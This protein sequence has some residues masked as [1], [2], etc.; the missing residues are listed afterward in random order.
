MKQPIRFFSMGL[1]TASLIILIVIYFFDDSVEHTSEGSVDE[2]IENLKDE[3]YHILSSSEYITLTVAN[4]TL[5]DEG[6]SEEQ[7]TDNDQNQEENTED[8]GDEED[9][10]DNANDEQDQN[11]NSDD[12]NNEQADEDNAEDVY[13]YTL[14]I[15]PNMLGPTIS[16]LLV[17][18]NIID[19]AEEFN[20]YLEI[21]G[22]APY[23]QLGEHD[24]SSDMSSYEIAE[25]IA[26]T[27]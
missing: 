9:N 19:D 23:L 24:L 27:R 2:M 7:D 11:E 4:K 1:L 20:R 21:E 8:I 16:E 15:E 25:A 6:N 12:A 3:G 13:E 5:D 14:V 18:H 26:T 17:D 10:S 22:Y